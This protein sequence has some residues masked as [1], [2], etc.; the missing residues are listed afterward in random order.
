MKKMP[1]MMK[2]KPTTKATKTPAP[3]SMMNKGAKKK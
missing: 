2:A 1:K 3:K